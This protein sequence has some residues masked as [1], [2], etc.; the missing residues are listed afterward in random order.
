MAGGERATPV[1]STLHLFWDCWSARSDPVRIYMDAGTYAIA[2]WG[3]ERAAARAC[4]FDVSAPR[5][6]RVTA[7]DRGG[8]ACSEANR[9][10]RRFLPNLRQRGT[11]AE[12]LRCVSGTVD[13][14]L[15]DTQALGVLGSRTA[16][17][18]PG[19]AGRCAGRASRRRM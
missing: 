18:R 8:R 3:V 7:D 4:A 5:C 15:D 12:Y 16:A 14:V 1:T 2:R 17:V 13:L 6:R 19:G 10:R 9:R 11:T